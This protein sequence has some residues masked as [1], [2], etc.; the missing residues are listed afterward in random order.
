M[1]LITDL[2]FSAWMPLDLLI[3]HVHRALKVMYSYRYYNYTD[4]HS[5]R[6]LHLITITPIPH[7]LYLFMLFSMLFSEKF[8]IHQPHPES[9]VVS[10]QVVI[11][12][13]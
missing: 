7:G 10:Y 6:L 13:I 8:F 1:P 12:I 5:S 4:G 11:T 2:G 3:Q 9:I